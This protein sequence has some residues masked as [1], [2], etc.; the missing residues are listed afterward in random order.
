MLRWL[1]YE[2]WPR[3]P[4]DAYVPKTDGTEQPLSGTDYVQNSEQPD[5]AALFG[6]R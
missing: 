4:S 3:R 2:G 5:L 1:P 6:D